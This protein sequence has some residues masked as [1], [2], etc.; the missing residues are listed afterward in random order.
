M[1]LAL[2]AVPSGAATAASGPSVGAVDEAPDTL[3]AI[4]IGTNSVH[5]VV[6]RVV[7]DGFETITRDRTMVRLGSG[8][9]DMKW[10]ADDAIDRGIEALDRCRQVAEVHHAPIRA[11]ATSAVREADNRDVFVRRAR[12]EA[13]VVVEVVS[14]V[15]EAR[16]I[17]LGVL[18]GVPLVGRR[19]LVVDIGVG[20]TEFVLAEG[21]AE[22]DARSLKL[23]AIRLTERFFRAERVEPAQVSACREHV[24]SYLGPV[25]RAAAELGVEVAV[26]SS[27]TITNLA[28]MV[29]AARGEVGAAAAN[30]TFSAAELAAVVAD[31]I[32]APTARARAR[33]PG[34]DPR[35]GDII[36]AG[37]VLLD[38][39]FAALSLEAMTV[40]PYALR[41]GLLLDTLQRR[42]AT[43][44]HRLGDIRAEG[45]RRLLAQ[46]RPD[47]VAHATHT[48]RLALELFDATE[49]R[50]HLGPDWREFLEAAAL[51]ANVGLVISHAGHHL[52]SYYVIRNSE[53][54]RGFT[55]R[56]VELIAQVARYHRK[57]VPRAKHPAF[58]ALGPEDQEG[59]RV[60]AGV[61]RVAIA[62]D[63]TRAGVV[64][65]VHVHDDGDVVTLRLDARGDASL[66]RYTAEERRDLLAAALGVD[67]RIDA[68]AP[69]ATAADGGA[70]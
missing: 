58:E 2:V 60:L 20:S 47:E 55:E 40:S 39:I 35:R 48:A 34:L 37:G 13:G 24:R 26:G 27:G 38:E 64:R 52:H 28:E 59:V 65:H 4:D 11:V 21:A 7:D 54:L 46:G 31:L 51:L 9:G 68:G 22:R 33:I 70:S 8:S 15:E 62:L 6:A 66:E 32:E 44:R 57:S 17:H 42:Q 19:H 63:R 29:L 25:V 50:H 69:A 10:L 36:V 3:A 41:E 14:G 1:T 43:A 67:V 61:L 49:P 56:E 18:Q 23:G 53:Q 45:V 5:L 12:D 30:A 16:L